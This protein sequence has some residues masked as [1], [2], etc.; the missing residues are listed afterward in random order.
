MLLKILA[1]KLSLDPTEPLDDHIGGTYEV[2]FDYMLQMQCH[3]SGISSL[4]TGILE[5]STNLSANM[6]IVL[7]PSV[8]RAKHL[9]ARKTLA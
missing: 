7:V 5:S 9:L 4:P 8:P 1:G 2:D 3:R 6:K